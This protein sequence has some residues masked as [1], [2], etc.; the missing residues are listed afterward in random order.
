MT[1][2]ITLAGHKVTGM[3]ATL[4]EAQKAERCN[5]IVETDGQYIPM[6]VKRAWC[7]GASAGCPASWFQV[8]VAWTLEGIVADTLYEAVKASW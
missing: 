4:E 5:R 1:T 8:N 3:H 7:L 6:K 2:Y